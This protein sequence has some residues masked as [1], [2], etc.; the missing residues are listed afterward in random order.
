MKHYGALLYIVVHCGILDNNR[1]HWISVSDSWRPLCSGKCNLLEYIK[2]KPFCFSGG[3]HQIN[4]VLVEATIKLWNMSRRILVETTRKHKK[5]I[6]CWTLP[7]NLC[8]LCSCR[9]NTC[10][11]PNGVWS[12]CRCVGSSRKGKSS[13]RF[14]R[15][16]EFTVFLMRPVFRTDAACPKRTKNPGG[17]HVC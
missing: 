6:S 17:A 1:E 10:A 3:R 8:K 5:N 13:A 12:S 14:A 15:W 4:I 7:V 16:K 9:D 11:P 2:N